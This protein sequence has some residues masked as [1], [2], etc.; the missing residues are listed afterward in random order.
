MEEIKEETRKYDYSMEVE[1]Y[2]SI[3]SRYRAQ[4]ASIKASSDK[5][6]SFLEDSARRADVL[7]DFIQRI[8]TRK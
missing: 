5:Q 4:A 1:H 6:I 7:A 2:R 8:C 3:A